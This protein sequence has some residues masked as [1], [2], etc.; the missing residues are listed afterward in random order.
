MKEARGSEMMSLICVR[1]T[2]ELEKKYG[3]HLGLMNPKP[4][5]KSAFTISNCGELQEQF[6]S[7]IEHEYS[8]AKK[9]QSESQKALDQ[10]EYKF[11]FLK[12]KEIQEYL[13]Q[14]HI[15]YIGNF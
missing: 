5:E 13:K 11:S 8:F 10:D 15:E 3:V 6:C 12:N 14:F 1:E 4:G 9:E 2:E 7:Y